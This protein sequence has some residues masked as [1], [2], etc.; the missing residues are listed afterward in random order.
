MVPY[1]GGTQGVG[2]LMFCGA[3]YDSCYDTS[4]GTI[5]IG[6]RTRPP[7][8]VAVRYAYR[9]RRRPKLRLPT[10]V[11]KPS[12]PSRAEP[13]LQPKTI[14]VSLKSTRRV[15]LVAWTRGH[16]PKDLSLRTLKMLTI[17]RR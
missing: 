9:S 16:V 8:A 12:V 13:V 15:T 17:T 3:L 1:G 5:T 2:T 7:V 6:A 10:I 14:E 11:H 4:S